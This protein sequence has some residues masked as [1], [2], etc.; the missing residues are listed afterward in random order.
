MIWVY[1]GE[2]GWLE[3]VYWGCFVD[4]I[5]I[6]YM[7]ILDLFMF[8]YIWFFVVLFVDLVGSK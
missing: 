4:I 2:I 3:S 8:M 5:L 6:V 7:E 1:I